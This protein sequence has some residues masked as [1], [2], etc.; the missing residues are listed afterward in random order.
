MGSVELESFLPDGDDDD[1]DDDELTRARTWR[2][3]GELCEICSDADATLEVAAVG[4]RPTM[5]CDRCAR[6]RLG[7]YDHPMDAMRAYLERLPWAERARRAVV[8]G[9]ELRSEAA[10]I[11]AAAL[12]E[13]HKTHSWSAVAAAT[14]LTAARV[15]NIASGRDRDRREAQRRRR[16]FG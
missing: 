1:D 16:L 12:R 2:R 8:V 11:R 13:G 15:A 14:G 7:A 10:A 3:A 6:R 4:A 5:M 9:E